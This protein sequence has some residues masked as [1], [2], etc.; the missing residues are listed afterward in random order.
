[1]AELVV[2][3]DVP[4]LSRARVLLHNLE[5]IVTHFKVGLELFSAAGPQAVALVRERGGVVVLD[6]KLHDIPHTVAGAVRAA[7]RL[8]ASYLTVHLAGGEAMVRAAVAAAREAGGP[9]LLGVT[10]LTSEPLPIG[11]ENDHDRR[12]QQRA[13]WAA[14]LG[15]GGAVV[16]VREVGLV[17]A[18]CPRGFLTLTPGVRPRGWPAEDQQRVATPAEA[19]QAGAD[20]VV[21]GRPIVRAEDPAAAA[22]AVLEELRLGT[23]T[24][25]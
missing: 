24:V 11:Q 23:A 13:Q 18:A 4:E 17:R 5:G 1:V 22:R 21:V 8:G 12:V 16:A 19:A 2:A 25:G 7:A 15:M 10:H 9:R 3:L 14:S 20:L 6:L